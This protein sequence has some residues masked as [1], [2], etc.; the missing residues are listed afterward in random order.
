MLF[1]GLINSKFWRVTEV[2]E[3]LK[4]FSNRQCLLLENLLRSS[5]LE[6]CSN[7]AVAYTVVI[8]V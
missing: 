2:T 6:K 3:I 1:K 5:N 8:L 4:L 7:C